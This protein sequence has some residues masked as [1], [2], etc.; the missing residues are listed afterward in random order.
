MGLFGK[1]KDDKKLDLHNKGE[2]LLKLERYEEALPYFRKALELD[3]EHTDSLMGMVFICN[4]LEMFEHIPD[5]TDRIILID[6]AYHPDMVLGAKCLAL[7]H[8]GRFEEIL[9][10]S[11]ILIECYPEQQAGWKY[12]GLVLTKLK[13]YEESLEYLNEA[14]NLDPTSSDS[15][16]MLSKTLSFLERYEESIAC[17]DQLIKLNP[18]DVGA[19]DDKFILLYALERYEEAIACC[20]QLIK[21]NPVFQHAKGNMLF[22]KLQKYEEALVCFDEVI[23]FNPKNSG[24]W[25]NKG[26]TLAEIGRDDEAKQCFR[27]A[28]DLDES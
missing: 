26:K 11:E 28:T 5:I 24:G 3:P 20:D 27:K 13:R 14:V 7:A 23:R 25:Y 4:K 6:N 22:D 2:S 10:Y 12:K 15:L 9:P 16:S 21:L 17:C 19:L 18:N 8:L 1:S